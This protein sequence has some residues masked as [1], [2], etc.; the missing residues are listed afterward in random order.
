MLWPKICGE[1]NFSSPKHFSS[2]SR[3]VL[4]QYKVEKFL[5]D[6]NSFIFSE[7]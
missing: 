6:E 2:Q 7:L 1:E 4:L 3:R 5:I